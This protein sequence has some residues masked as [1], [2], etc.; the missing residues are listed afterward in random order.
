MWC[1]DTASADSNQTAQMWIYTVH[2]NHMVGF[3]AAAFINQK[4]NSIEPCLK[5]NFSVIFKGETT[6]MTS[7]LA[8]LRVCSRKATLKENNLFHWEYFPARVNVLACWQEMAFL[9]K[10]SALQVYLSKGIMHSTEAQICLLSLQDEASTN[11]KLYIWLALIRN[12][13]CSCLTNSRL[14]W[15]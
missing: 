15:G 11:F 5:H 7:C 1:T 10:L 9:L 4:Y 12:T 2:R 6:F 8:F 14:G 13:G 3:P